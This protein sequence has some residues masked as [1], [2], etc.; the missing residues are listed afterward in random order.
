[1]TD[2]KVEAMRLLSNMQ[3][4]VNN[5][6]RSLIDPDPANSIEYQYKSIGDWKVHVDGSMK[7]VLKEIQ[8]GVNNE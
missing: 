2:N 4:S 1:M 5:L 7:K 8:K 6:M 3:N